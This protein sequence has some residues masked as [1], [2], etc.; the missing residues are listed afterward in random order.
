MKCEECGNF[1]YRKKNG[2]PVCKYGLNFNFQ[3][4]AYDEEVVGCKDAEIKRFKVITAIDPGCKGEAI[5][6]TWAVDGDKNVTILS[7][8]RIPISPI[9]VPTT[10]GKP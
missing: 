2:E 5:I 6:T 1:G 7:N 4:Q 8:E 10:E 3:R 9:F